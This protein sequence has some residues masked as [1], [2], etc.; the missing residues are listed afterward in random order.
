MLLGQV[1]QSIASWQKLSGV[2]LKAKLA[3]KLLKYTTLVSAEH[4]IADKQRVALIH[5]ITGTKEGEDAKIEPDSP[6]IREYAGKFNEIMLTESTLE[7]LDMDFEEVINAVDEKDESLTVSDL[8]MLQPFF[9]PNKEA[10]AV[11]KTD[12]VTPP[13]GTRQ[14]C[15]QH[16]EDNGE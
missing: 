11:E 16:G 9:M 5:E 1:F 8:A 13:S 3:Y 14:I 10:V 6:E 7:Q 12:D 15:R 2:N 4:A